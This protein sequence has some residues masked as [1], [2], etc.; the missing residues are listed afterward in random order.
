MRLEW[1]GQRPRRPKSGFLS[2]DIEEHKA[3]LQISK[4]AARKYASAQA[5]STTIT[6]VAKEIA[7]QENAACAA[8]LK[9]ALPYAL[10]LTGEHARTGTKFNFMA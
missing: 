7:A 4:E 9:Q 2:A 1:T 3:M 6:M 5:T 8:P 10:P